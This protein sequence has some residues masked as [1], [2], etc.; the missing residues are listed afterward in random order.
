MII[1]GQKKEKKK[2][3][4]KQNPKPDKKTTKTKRMKKK[5]VVALQSSLQNAFPALELPETATLFN[6]LS[7][8]GGVGELL[9]CHRRSRGDTE[10]EKKKHSLK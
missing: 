5:T 10:K 2:K 6:D 7:L 3:S 1:C 4:A 9:D 8:N